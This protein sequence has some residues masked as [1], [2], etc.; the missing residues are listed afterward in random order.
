MSPLRTVYGRGGFNDSDIMA[1]NQPD[2][3]REVKDFRE[4]AV[5]AS[6]ADEEDTLSYFAKLA[7]EE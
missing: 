5:A 3:G 1:S 7:E 4:T 2:W 6:V